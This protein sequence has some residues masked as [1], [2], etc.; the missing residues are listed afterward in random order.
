MQQDDW[1]HPAISNGDS[2]DRGLDA[3]IAAQE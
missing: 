1:F 2:V 3:V